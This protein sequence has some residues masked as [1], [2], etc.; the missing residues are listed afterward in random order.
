MFSC[1]NASDAIVYNPDLIFDNSLKINV[2]PYTYSD[3]GIVYT[4]LGDSASVA[5]TVSS[6]PVLKW[7][8]SW[9]DVVTVAISTA[10]F[11]VEDGRI[12]NADQIIW[13]WHP[14][15]SEGENGEVAYLDGKPVENEKIL[16]E[17]QPLPLENGLYFWAVWSWD[18]GARYVIYST[19]EQL[20]YVN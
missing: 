10:P 19:K 15:L 5:D 14:G 17:K 2:N 18:K 8:K 12:S 6:T 11:E 7:S 9:S 20:M 1:N 3:S 13:L 4:V 16:N